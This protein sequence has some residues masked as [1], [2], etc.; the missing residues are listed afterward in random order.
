M[1]NLNQEGVSPE[2]KQ[3]QEQFEIFKQFMRLHRA[4][5]AWY[6]C[7]NLVTV[8]FELNYKVLPLRGTNLAQRSYHGKHVSESTFS[9]N[10]ILALQA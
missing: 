6:P 1:L 8:S 9:T 10:E 2:D 3:A 4:L 5:V 7:G